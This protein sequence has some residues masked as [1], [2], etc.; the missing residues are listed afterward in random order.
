MNDTTNILTDG[1]VTVAEAAKFL[2]IGRS[3]LYEIMDRGELRYV[4]LGTARRIPRRSL[5]EL[6][7]A[8]LKGGWSIAT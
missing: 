2:S 1:L 3:K 5:V 6:A 8:N 7:E 4:K